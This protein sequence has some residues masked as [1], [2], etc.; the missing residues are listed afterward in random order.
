LRRKEVI[1]GISIKVGVI[2][3]KFKSFSTI[4]KKPAPEKACSSDELYLSGPFSEQSFASAHLGGK[5]GIEIW[6]RI[7]NTTKT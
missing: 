6:H 1:I 5:M 3:D 4:A 7:M 2:N